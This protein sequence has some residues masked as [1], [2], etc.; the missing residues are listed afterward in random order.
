[1]RVDEMKQTFRGRRDVIL[2]AL[3][4]IEGVHCL[5]PGG[6]FYVWPNMT[7]VCDRL[8]LKD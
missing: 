4:G 1:M 8:G 2:E 6:A 3:N 7:G 5:E